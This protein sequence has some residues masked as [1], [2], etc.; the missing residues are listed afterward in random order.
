MD[1][2]QVSIKKL[3]NIAVVAMGSLFILAILFCRERVL[4]A[5]ASYVLFDIVNAKHLNIQEHRYGS[6]I[7]QLFPYMGNTGLLY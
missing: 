2:S 4:F 3:A 7:T 6:F 5:D 1:E